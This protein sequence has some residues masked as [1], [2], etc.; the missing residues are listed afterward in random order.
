MA[1][2]GRKT[3]LTRALYGQNR[4]VRRVVKWFLVIDLVVLVVICCLGLMH[5]MMVAGTR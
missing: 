3:P 5:Q 4:I 2:N 1:S